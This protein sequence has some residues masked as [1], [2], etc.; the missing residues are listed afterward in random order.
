LKKTLYCFSNV[1]LATCS[2]YLGFN[3]KDCFLKQWH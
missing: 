1:I 2:S 3:E